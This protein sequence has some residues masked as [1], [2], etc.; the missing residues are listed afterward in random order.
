MRDDFAKFEKAGASIIV[1]AKHS[2]E[3]MDKY[4]KENKLPYTG[5]PDP[6]GKVAKLYYQ[7]WKVLKLGLMPALFVI[8]KNGK[9]AFLHY[10]SSMSD[11]PTDTKVLAEVEKLK[12]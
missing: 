6:E 12:P 2:P 10:S 3:E 4:W 8:D 7:Q 11:I 1:V 5:I 9:I